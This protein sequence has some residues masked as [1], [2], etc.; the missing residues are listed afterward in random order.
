MLAYLVR[1]RFRAPPGYSYQRFFR[2]LY[3][4][5][6]VV[7]KSNGKTYIYRRPGVL[8]YYPYIHGA[9]NTI[10]IP[11]EALPPVI[12]F[13]KTGKNPC[14]E[15]EDLSSWNVSYYN[16]KQIFEHTSFFRNKEIYIC[17]N[18]NYTIHV[19]YK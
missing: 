14:H 9:K 2:A 6:Q 3:G 16:S 1:Y 10:I 17:L 4:Y 15:F 19:A 12:N 7:K 13:F 8:T 5:T 11:P 18:M